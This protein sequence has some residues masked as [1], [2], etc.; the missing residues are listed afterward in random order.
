MRKTSVDRIHSTLARLHNVHLRAARCET[1]RWL[2]LWGPGI[3]MSSFHEVENLLAGGAGADLF[4]FRLFVLGLTLC[5]FISS[6]AE[7]VGNDLIS[8][9]TR[10]PAT[11]GN[12]LIRPHEQLRR[13]IDVLKGGPI[14]AHHLERHPKLSRSCHQFRIGRGA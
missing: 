1:V 5:V 6:P 14:D 12:M 4:N 7:A 2:R 11:P 9:A 10:G 13:A 3:L 8:F